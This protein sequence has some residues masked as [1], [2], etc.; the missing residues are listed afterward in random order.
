MTSRCVSPRTH[1]DRIAVYCYLQGLPIGTQEC[2]T[3]SAV[4]QMVTRSDRP[5]VAVADLRSRAKGTAEP[6]SAAC[7]CEARELSGANSAASMVSSASKLT[8]CMAQV[9]SRAAGS[10]SASVQPFPA[11]AAA[12]NALDVPAFTIS[13]DR[14]PSFCTQAT[15]GPTL[16]LPTWPA[17]AAAAALPTARHA[18]ELPACKQACAGD[19][20]ICIRVAHGHSARLWAGRT[21]GC[22]LWPGFSGTLLGKHCLLTAGS[23]HPGS[24]RS[25][26]QRS[27]HLAERARAADSTACTTASTPV[28][29]QCTAVRLVTGACTGCATAAGGRSSAAQPAAEQPASGW[30]WLLS[31]AAEL[32]EE[33]A[34]ERCTPAAAA[35][36]DWSAGGRRASCRAQ[37]LS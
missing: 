11:A 32:P 19:A 12:A 35:C 17:A 10:Y 9:N 5:S 15:P 28:L 8:T 21:W 20:E 1:F 23:R 25:A 33:P 31:R 30:A 18:A 36:A 13:P 24:R 14:I 27:K 3:L 4:W 26:R 2:V 37:P 6:A 34:G 7:P 16:S 22:L 29:I